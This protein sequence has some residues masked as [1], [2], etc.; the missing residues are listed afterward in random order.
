[1]SN[2]K[3]PVAE[4]ALGLWNEIVRAWQA[5]LIVAGSPGSDGIGP[6]KRPGPPPERPK[7]GVQQ[8]SDPRIHRGWDSDRRDWKERNVR[9]EPRC[10]TPAGTS[11]KELRLARR[12]TRQSPLGEPPLVITTHVIT[13]FMPR[14]PGSAG[15]QPR[16]EAGSSPSRHDSRDPNR[17]GGCAAQGRQ[18][19][20]SPQGA[21]DQPA[22]SGS[23]V[24]SSGLSTGK[25]RNSSKSR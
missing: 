3:S 24:N 23:A 10:A 8:I 16:A 18:R 22:N 1:M 17:P 4:T 20:Y 2:K 15:V 6:G 14:H 9:P 21:R 12:A 19:N 7:R 5:A 13:S 25:S 11:D